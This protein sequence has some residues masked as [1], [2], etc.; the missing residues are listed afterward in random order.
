MDLLGHTFV[1]GLRRT[2]E[3][4]LLL[5]LYLVGLLAGLV[6]TWPLFVLGQNELLTNPLLAH[7]AAGGS[8][9]LVNLAVGSEAGPE[10]AAAVSS[11]LVVSLLLTVLFSLAYNFFAGGILSV[12]RGKRTFWQGCW[13]FVLTFIGMGMLLVILGALTTVIVTLPGMVPGEVRLVAA[14][15]LIQLI[16]LLGEYGRA[17]AVTYNRHNSFMLIW[18]A[19][20]FCWDN[21]GGVV[22]L[23]LLGLL[24]HGMVAVISTLLAGGIGGTFVAIV[25]Q[26]VVVVAWLWLK[27]LRLGWALSYVEAASA[28]KLQ[29]SELRWA[30]GSS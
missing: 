18:L 22:T 16:N 20:R 24:F 1:T 28:I 21:A 11:W 19:A 7:L 6:Q 2:L 29:A 17:V 12:W 8:N 3:W 26:Q 10:I 14:F 23:A 27:L 4:R 5:P 13:R 9:T 15:V 25:V 30:V